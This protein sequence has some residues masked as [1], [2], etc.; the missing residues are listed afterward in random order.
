MATPK[1]TEKLRQKQSFPAKDSISKPLGIWR[2]FQKIS[3]LLLVRKLLSKMAF[4]SI[5][6][7]KIAGLCL[8]I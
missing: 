6:L 2:A 4:H 7:H 3:Q 5:Q 8:K 1:V